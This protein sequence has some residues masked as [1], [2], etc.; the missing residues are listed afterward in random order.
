MAPGFKA[1]DLS[2]VP[3]YNL[4]HRFSWSDGFRVF[5]ALASPYESASESLLLEF[6]K[7]SMKGQQVAQIGVGDLQTNPCFRFN[8]TSFRVGCASTTANCDFNVTGLAWDEVSETEI[9][10]A[11]HTFTTRA[12]S[13]QKNC[14][15][16]FLDADQVGILNNLTSLL[17]DVTAHGQ[18][19]KWWADDLT[20]TW[21]DSSCD[22]AVCRSHVRDTV[23]KRG[24]R[25]GLSR[26]SDHL[27]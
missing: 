13:A 9:P 8:F 12:C 22:F 7:S 20:L 26:V 15:L 4:Y 24:R 21:T 1:N 25:H 23:P 18:P 14:E 5:P 10:V 3:M 11:S 19:Q 6:S 17:F 16:G 2:P 27:P